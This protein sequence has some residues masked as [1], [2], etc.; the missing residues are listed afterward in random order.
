MI[1]RKDE[2]T[3]RIDGRYQNRWKVCDSLGVMLTSSLSCD[4]RQ[5]SMVGETPWEIY[6][7]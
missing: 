1:F 6:D 4:S 7:N 3:L 5:F 2:W